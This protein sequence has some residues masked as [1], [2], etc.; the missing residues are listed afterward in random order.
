MKEAFVPQPGRLALSKAGR[1]KGRPV[2]ILELLDEQYVRVAD[3]RQRKL[4]RPKRKKLMH[5]RLTPHVDAAAAELLA[6]GRLK[7][8]DIRTA[9]DAHYPGDKEETACLSTT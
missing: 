6:A 7:N 8:S 3:G 9:I 1:D 4:E 2:M 5:L